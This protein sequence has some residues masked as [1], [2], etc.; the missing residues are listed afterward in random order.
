M[1]LKN[2]FCI[3]LR[4]FIE[5]IQMAVPDIQRLQEFIQLEWPKWDNNSIELRKLID[6]A[7][8]ALSPLSLLDRP[9]LSGLSDEHKEI[10][11]S[12]V[13]ELWLARS[14]IRQQI[15]SAE[16]ALRK[17]KKKSVIV[18]EGLKQI[19]NL[20]VSMRIQFA[21]QIKELENSVLKLSDAIS[22]FPHKIQ[23]V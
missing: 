18:S 21:M 12:V 1:W 4:G 2:E 6:S 16:A 8:I 7:E 9:P 11:K 14:P 20:N 15:E 5:R 23:V 13:H 10:L 17:A 22:C 19:E 3:Y